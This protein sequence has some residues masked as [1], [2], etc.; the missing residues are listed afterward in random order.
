MAETSTE[1]MQPKK[2]GM[3]FLSNMLKRFIKNGTLRVIESDGVLTEFKGT[4]EPV[5]TIHLHDPALP[6]KIFRNPELNT[7]EAYMDGTLTFE[8][9]TL[10]DFLNL[11]SLNRGSMASYPMQ[12]VLRRISRTV[13]SVQQHNPI[14][15][16]QKNVAHHYDLSAEMY[17]LFLDEDMQYSCAY[18]E[19]G[20]ESL[21]DAQE[22]KKRHI[23]AKLKLE[24]GQRILDIGCGWGGLA[25]YLAQH[26]NVE[27]LGVT[28]SE[29]QHQVAV[30][31][32]KNAGL[33]DRVQFELLDYRKVDDRFDR[34]VSVGMFEHVG[35]S[36]YDEF[37]GKVYELLQN[38]G[39]AVLHSIGHMSPPSVASPW[40]RK[41]IFPGAYSPALSETF[42]ATERQHLW[43][44]DVEVLRVHY[45][46]TLV[47]WNKRFQEN[48]ER[49]AEI[50]D[51]RFCRMWEFYLLSAETMFRTGAQMVFQMQ[52]S[53]IREATGL[54]RDYMFATEEMYRKKD[55]KQNY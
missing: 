12:K 44:S 13:R 35:V 47:E 15:K 14:G 46:D 7:G 25:L 42:A 22:K 21:E 40:L 54:T 45:A 48:R 9:C 16:A 5:A 39:F 51:E 19:N 3:A 1:K 17:S 27:V 38:D 53:R 50:Y 49:I 41:Y 18:F 31:R 37:F 26:A 52:L 4:V 34:I 36:R 55:T 10:K 30:E 33:S 23:A 6:F 2:L 11:F 20:D 24:D 43:V 29:E 32:T 28:L 8:D